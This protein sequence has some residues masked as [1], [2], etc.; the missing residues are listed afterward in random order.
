MSED[1]LRRASSAARRAAIA[2]VS[3]YLRLSPAV[4]A[5][6]R[7]EGEEQPE[8]GPPPRGTGILIDYA[9]GGEEQPSRGFEQ[10]PAGRYGRLDDGLFLEQM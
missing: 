4:P 2:R 6:N 3:P 10:E 8:E 1:L 7:H 5:E 9:P